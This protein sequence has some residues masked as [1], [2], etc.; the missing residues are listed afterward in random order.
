MNCFFRSS[1]SIQTHCLVVRV[2]CNELGNMGFKPAECWNALLPL[3][4]FAWHQACQCTDT[5]AFILLHSQFFFLSWQGPDSATCEGLA[6]GSDF[7]YCTALAVE[8][9]CLKRHGHCFSLNCRKY[10]KY[11]GPC[12]GFFKPHPPE[13]WPWHRHNTSFTSM[14]IMWT[15][16]L[17][18]SITHWCMNQCLVDSIMSQ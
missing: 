17:L 15:F 10:W 16:L 6:H 4:H 13:L 14:L 11:S 18:Q 3:G 9:K 2:I 12:W 1:E 7:S 8:Q 5:R